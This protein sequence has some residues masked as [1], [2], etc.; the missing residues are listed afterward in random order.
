[1]SPALAGVFFFTSATWEAHSTQE[2]IYNLNSSRSSRDI[3]QWKWNYICPPIV[4]FQELE[5]SVEDLWMDTHFS[6]NSQPAIQIKSYSLPPYLI[7][8]SL[9]CHAARESLDSVTLF[10]LYAE[11]NGT[12]LQCSCLENPRDRGASWAAV[13]GVAESQTRL[14][15]LSSS[16]SR[17]NYEK[18]WAGG[19]TS[20]NQDCRDQ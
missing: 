19:S 10:N 13:Y 4:K 16:S 8:D 2:H 9:A 15:R 20:W 6:K 18:C 7:S 17:V 1:M 12:P 14:K 11:F 5:N 3:F